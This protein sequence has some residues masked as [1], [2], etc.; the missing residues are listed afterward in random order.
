MFDAPVGAIT[1]VATA[2]HLIEVRWGR[3]AS[4]LESRNA[5][6]DLAIDQLHSYFAGRRLEFDLPLK[7][8]GTSFQ[9]RVW[10][11]L[12]QIPFGE[13]RTYAEQA[14]RLGAP[15]A[16]RA[17]GAANG[18]NPLGLFIPCHRVVGT[19]RKLT[20]FAGGLSIKAQLLEHERNVVGLSSA[21][22]RYQ[23]TN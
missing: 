20:G 19:N 23:L 2:E 12:K 5:I 13:V 7:P 17:V 22:A 16:C 1:L 4:G 8:K 11:E 15:N 6:I 18:R 9:L 14:R 3:T 10:D 21:E